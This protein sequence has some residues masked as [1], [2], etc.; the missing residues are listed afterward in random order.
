MVKSSPCARWA[1]YSTCTDG[2]ADVHFK[3]YVARSPLLPRYP[4]NVIDPPEIGVLAQMRTLCGKAAPTSAS[5]AAA[6]AA[7]LAPRMGVGL[8]IGT[9]M[10][11]LPPRYDPASAEYPTGAPDPAKVAW[12]VVIVGNG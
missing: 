10:K 7:T 4:R 5:K 1:P 11:L 12:A 6:F 9:S 3:E 8:A 2:D